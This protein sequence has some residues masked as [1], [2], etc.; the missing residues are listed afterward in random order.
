MQSISMWAVYTV[1]KKKKRMTE[2]ADNFIK[3]TPKHA[4]DLFITSSGLDKNDKDYLK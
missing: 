3:K 4:Y 1:G 2:K